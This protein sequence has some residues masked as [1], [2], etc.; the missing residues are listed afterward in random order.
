MKGHTLVATIFMNLSP[1]E[2]WDKYWSQ[3]AELWIGKFYTEKGEKRVEN[4]EWVTPQ[5]DEEKKYHE[6]AADS[7][8]LVIQ[9]YRKTFVEI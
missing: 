3:D 8:S 6:K 9:Q 2:F 1:N 7:S 4:G 5:T